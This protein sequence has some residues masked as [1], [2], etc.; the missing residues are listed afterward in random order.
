MTL[1]GQMFA[2]LTVPAVGADCAGDDLLLICQRQILHRRMT[3]PLLR[4]ARGMQG[5]DAVT[6]GHEK[7]PRIQIVCYHVAYGVGSSVKA[8]SFVNG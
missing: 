8:S 1:L 2:G 4:A 7:L 6:A 3:L 5:L